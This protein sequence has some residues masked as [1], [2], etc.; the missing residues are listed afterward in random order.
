MQTW[1]DGRAKATDASEA[2]RA[3]LASLGV[4][5]SAWSGIRPTVTF[6]GLAYVHLGMLPA[7]V[8]EQI[9][10]A[11]RVTETSAH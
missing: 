9:A 2:I 4:A 8:V 10:E 11:M 6:N 5:E 7:A 3:A 1:R